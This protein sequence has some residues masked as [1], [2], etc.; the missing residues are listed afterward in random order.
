LS[1]DFL[2]FAAEK[3][4]KF[5]FLADLFV[6]MTR[7]LFCYSGLAVRSLYTAVRAV[8]GVDSSLELGWQSSGFGAGV[9]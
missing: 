5:V 6:V 4:D 9:S 2:H 3:T 8:R 1:V 7:V